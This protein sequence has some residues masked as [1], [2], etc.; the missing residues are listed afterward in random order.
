MILRYVV[1][2]VLVLNVCT[3]NGVVNVEL[4][5]LKQEMTILE[6][7]MVSVISKSENDQSE[8]NLLGILQA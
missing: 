3:C 7:R 2:F 6:S 4:E 5:G 1:A 8:V